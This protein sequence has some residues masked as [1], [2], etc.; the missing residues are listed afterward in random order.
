[1]TT[2]ARKGIGLHDIQTMPAIH[3]RHDA[4][5]FKARDAASY[6]PIARKFDRWTTRFTTPLAERLVE[7]ARLK[8][9]Q[10]ALDIGAGTGV[11]ALAAA[12][13]VG[14]NGR[15]LGIDLSEGMLAVA[16]VKAGR[17]GLNHVR[18]EKMDAERLEIPDQSFDAVLSLYALLHFPHPATA[19]REMH[20]VLR[21]GGVLAVGV[22]SR[23]P[24][25]LRGI[26]HR[27]RRSADLL[28]LRN[29]T[30]L[31]APRFLDSLVQRLLPAP[32]Q[33][34]ESPLA[35]RITNRTGSLLRLAREA[36]FIDV[37]S[38]W[39][40][41]ADAMESPHDFWELQRTYSSIA[42]KRLAEAQPERTAAVKKEFFERCRATQARGGRLMY[43]HAAFYV[44]AR[45][46][47]SS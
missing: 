45:R 23:P 22:G 4:E 27:L 7:L 33:P 1:M 43:H 40:G 39:Q 35:A 46:A 24:L 10:E 28:R 32:A 29:G 6:D 14:R 2:N 38:S 13:K 36:G 37:H 17:A 30:L 34:E 5:E 20:R 15:V 8:G 18:F 47:P 9:G 42:R 16:A 11:V 3:M 26:A 44:V 12:D 25:N 31:L 21:P 41:R 19:L